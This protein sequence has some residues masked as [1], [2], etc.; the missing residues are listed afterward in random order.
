[1]YVYIYICAL[2]SYLYSDD[3]AHILKLNCVSR[4]GLRVFQRLFN[5]ID[6]DCCGAEL[7]DPLVRGQ[8]NRDANLPLLLWDI[9][10]I[11]FKL[12]RYAS[13]IAPSSQYRMKK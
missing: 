4:K 1:M 8:S 2:A 9:F 10:Y 13:R 3:L 7:S 12:F 5:S 11:T 6:K